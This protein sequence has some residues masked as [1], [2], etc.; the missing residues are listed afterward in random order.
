[1]TALE[2]S[3]PWFE[4][5]PVGLEY[6]APAMTLT[7]GHAAYYQALTGDRLALPLDHVTARAVTGCDSPLAN[8]LLAV[9][10]AIGQ[11]TWA[12][13]RVKAN[14]GYRGL[15]LVRPVHLGDTLY[16]RT[17]VVGARLNRRQAGRAA[18]GVVAL[19][20]YTVNQRNERVMH[21]WRFPMIPCRDPQAITGRDDSLDGIGAAVEP[22][23]LRAALPA[24]NLGALRPSLVRAAALTA[25]QRICAE[26]RDTVTSAPELV[27][28]TLN[29]AMAH[30]DAAVSHTN[31]R[32]VYGGHTVA[33]AFAQVTRLLPQL[34]TV[35]A[36]D[37]CDH[38]AP[39]HEGDRLRTEVEVL[40]V[41]PLPTGALVRLR[42]ECF[43]TRAADVAAP[44]A[45][46]AQV[47]RWTF[48]VWS[49]A[50]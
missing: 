29:L 26:A 1:V 19:E 47:L 3:A 45:T 49:A 46:E 11:T 40:A 13:Q 43:A 23:A 33:M 42:A 12:S 14:L 9:N 32:L 30:T 27:R 25:G 7:A 28:L 21:C 48:W 4:D 44:P 34:V 38:T 15:H 24:W 8:P 36:W 22:A 5:L 31:A 50:A 41:E 10:V 2:P 37:S 18:T 16:T 39:V 20:S 35:L 17:R 6:D